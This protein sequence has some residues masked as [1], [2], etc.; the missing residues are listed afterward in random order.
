MTFYAHILF[1]KGRTFVD[2]GF[3]AGDT[4]RAYLFGG[5][6]DMPFRR[7]FDIR[8]VQADYIHTALLGQNQNNI[9][10]STGLVYRW[11]SVRRTKHRAPTTQTP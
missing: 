11:G 6:V 4:Q 3:G 8:I 10:L 5:G 1:G 7:H 2:Q 9:R